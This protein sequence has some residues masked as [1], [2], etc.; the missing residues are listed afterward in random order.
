MKKF[1][2]IC[3]KPSI[4]FQHHMKTAELICE[5]TINWRSFKLTSVLCRIKKKIWVNFIYLKK[6]LTISQWVFRWRVVKGVFIKGWVE[7]PKV[8][9]SVQ[10]WNNHHEQSARLL[11]HRNMV[12]VLLWVH[13]H[14]ETHT[15][16]MMKE[17]SADD[18][19]R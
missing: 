13:W 5:R 18:R 14:H 15:G 8:Q 19:T 16:P 6:I 3:Y 9:I 10:L 2:T 12:D 1:K 11:G 7:S 17:L 4:D